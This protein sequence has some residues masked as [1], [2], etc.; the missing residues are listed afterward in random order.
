MTKQ[1]LHDILVLHFTEDV[2]QF[3]LPVNMASSD[4]LKD[5]LSTGG[6]VLS[7]YSTDSLLLVFSGDMDKIVNSFLYKLGYELVSGVK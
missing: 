4:L 2:T 5:L 1:F 7:P 6:A 3:L